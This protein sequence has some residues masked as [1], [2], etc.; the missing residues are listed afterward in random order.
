M[1][2]IACW[3]D[4]TD[5]HLYGYGDKFPHDGRAIPEERIDELLTAENMIGYPLIEA[6]NEQEPVQSDEQPK[7]AAKTPKNE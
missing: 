5:G 2:S 6:V 3:V 4:V 1:R 7:K